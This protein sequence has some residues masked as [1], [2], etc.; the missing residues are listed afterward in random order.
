MRKRIAI[1]GNNSRLGSF[2][3]EKWCAEHYTKYHIHLIFDFKSEL[4][5]FSTLVEVVSIILDNRSLINVLKSYN[6]GHLIL[7]DASKLLYLS[8]FRNELKKDNISV[9]IEDTK[10]LKTHLDKYKSNLC[11]KENYLPIPEFQLLSDF[12]E[13]PKI[14]YPVIIKPNRGFASKNISKINSNEE[15]QKLEIE[16]EDRTKFI[17][18]KYLRGKEFSCTVVRNKGLKFMSIKRKLFKEYTISSQYKKEYQNHIEQWLPFLDK[19]EFEYAINVQY[20]LTKNGVRIFEINP[21]LG[22][23]ETHRFEYNFDALDQILSKKHPS[24]TQYKEGSFKIA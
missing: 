20:I 6:I 3:L 17:V 10:F 21:R 24:K 9:Y 2:L 14:E 16:K 8:S 12:I 1:Y 23:A 18:Q 19:L 7:L 15:L 13:D 11:L 4:N 5:H 22:T